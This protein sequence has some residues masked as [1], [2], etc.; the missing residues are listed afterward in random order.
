MKAEKLDN[1][2]VYNIPWG[3]EGSVQGPVVTLSFLNDHDGDVSSRT[4]KND[5]NS[6][7][8]VATGWTGSDTCTVVGSDSGSFSF[9]VDFDG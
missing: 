5:G 6:E 8:T 9:A 7:V 2:D 1:R 3:Q 4:D